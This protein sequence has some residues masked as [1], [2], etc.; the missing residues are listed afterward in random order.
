[1]PSCP[2]ATFSTKPEF[3]RT[4]MA[5]NSWVRS[6]SSFDYLRL[7]RANTAGH[8]GHFDLL[9]DVE[10]GRPSQYPYEEHVLR[11]ENSALC[12]YQPTSIFS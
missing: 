6:L 10:E 3:F 12:S 7:S 11:T 8:P 4:E 1:M 2:K 9:P 5:A